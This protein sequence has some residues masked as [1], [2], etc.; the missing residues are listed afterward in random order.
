MCDRF[1]CSLVLLFAGL[2]P[3][4]AQYAAFKSADGILLISQ[5]PSQYFSIDLPGSK[6]M[7][8]GQ[9]SMSHPSF[10]ICDSPDDQPRNGRFVQVMPVPLSEFKGR[11]NE[12]D[13]TLLS[14]QA[15]YEIGYWHPRDSQRRLTTLANGRTALIW[16]LTLA[17]KI[18]TGSMQLFL[19]F[20]QQDYV[21][22]LSSNVPDDR[23]PKSIESYLRRVALSFRADN[24][25]IPTPVPG[26]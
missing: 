3:A 18:R 8:V 20:R 14:R 22:V 12:S 25:P 23:D 7:P 16:K 6:I 10:I 13:Q 9:K 2:I 19:S 11:P 24:H 4:R 21:V 5:R 26:R 1:I 17:K 15:D